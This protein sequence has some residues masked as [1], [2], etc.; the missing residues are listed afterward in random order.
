MT[1]AGRAYAKDGALRWDSNN[2]GVAPDAGDAGFQ[3]LVMKFP[4]GVELAL[5][6]NSLPGFWR[7]MSKMAADAYDDAWE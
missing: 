4:N 3:T 6:I 1:Y 5:A 2:N 7:G